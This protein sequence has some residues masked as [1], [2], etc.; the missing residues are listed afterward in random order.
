[1]NHELIT[2]DCCPV[3]EPQERTQGHDD[4]TDE[5]QGRSKIAEM[6]VVRKFIAFCHAHLLELL[7]VL[8]VL[9]LVGQLFWPSLIRWQRLP[10]PGRIGNDRFTAPYLVSEC[11]I[12]LPTGYDGR[13]EWPLVVF[14]H[15]RGERAVERIRNVPPLHLD[16]PAVVAV[17]ICE[18]PTG[19]HPETVIAFVNQVINQYRVNRQQI[20]LV[21]HSMGG[22]GVVATAA[23]EPKLFAAVVPISGGAG[24]AEVAPLRTLPVWAFH[25]AKDEVVPVSE[26]EHLIEAIRSAG[27][28]PRFT[29][30]PAGGHGICLEVCQRKDVWQWLF[31]QRRTD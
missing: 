18:P 9:L 25:G 20:Y 3:H 26:S 12:Y 22:Y 15:G 16:L 17:P 4:P 29:I 5:L 19:W 6:N 23:S 27:G 13:H 10:A 14:L 28:Q 24:A 7:L 31:A 11:P 21:G 2:R 1:M 30:L 8:T